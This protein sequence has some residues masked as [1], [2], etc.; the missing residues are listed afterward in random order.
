MY[1][2][3]FLL[4]INGFQVLSSEGKLYF[5]RIGR[6]VVWT[7]KAHYGDEERLFGLDTSDGKKI[8]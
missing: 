4:C 5:T 6:D 1:I 7:K 8:Q 3:L 2:F